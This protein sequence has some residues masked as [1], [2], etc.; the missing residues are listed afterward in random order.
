MNNGP[1]HFMPE[2]FTSEVEPQK[3]VDQLY[4]ELSVISKIWGIVLTV[5]T[6]LLFFALLMGAK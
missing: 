2:V 5:S 1:E 3:T 4:S 6:A